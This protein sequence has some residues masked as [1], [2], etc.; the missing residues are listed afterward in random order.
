MSTP[1]SPATIKFPLD[2]IDQDVV[3]ALEEMDI[4]KEGDSFKATYQEEITVEEG[5]FSLYDSEARYGEF[6]ELEALLVKK[7]IP[8]DRQSVQD[9]DR[10]PVL[11]VFRP[12]LMDHYF[13][14]N[15]EGETVVN[16][17]KIRKFLDLDDA[18]EEAA[19]AIRAYLDKEFPVYPPVEPKSTEGKPTEW[20][21]RP[22]S[23]DLSG[24]RHY[25]GA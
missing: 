16:V 22:D 21:L 23:R 14:Q 5:I 18:G 1:T 6:D 10:P 9:W 20:S 3:E 11:R 24:P 2:R 7:D 12:G 25:G 15:E 4:I 17:A 13:P 19:S 8:F